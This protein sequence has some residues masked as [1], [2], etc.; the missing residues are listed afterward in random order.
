[1]SETVKLWICEIMT[2]KTE[3]INLM[4]SY[5]CYCLSLFGFINWNI[6]VVLEICMTK[7]LQT[8]QAFR[9]DIFG[10]PEMLNSWAE[11]SFKVISE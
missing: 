3:W 5:S 1:M 2:V 4:I 8:K 7:P 11:K 9:A 10:Y 6:H